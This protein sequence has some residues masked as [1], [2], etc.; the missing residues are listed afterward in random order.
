MVSSIT[1]RQASSGIALG[2]VLAISIGG[3]MLFFLAAGLLLAWR[4]KMRAKPYPMR[5]Y[6]LNP[7]ASSQPTS[8][9][10]LTKQRS[11][12][13][14]DLSTSRF[15]SRLSIS[16]PPVPLLPPL[17]T[18]NSIRT[19]AGGV[20]GGG[21]DGHAGRGRSRTWVDGD[22]LHG[23]QMGRSARES[24]FRSD[25]SVFNFRSPTLPNFDAAEQGEAQPPEAAPAAAAAA[26]A[27]AATDVV[28][29]DGEKRE[30]A[31]DR[32]IEVVKRQSRTM[33][34][35][36]QTVPILATTD[37]AQRGRARVP[38][39]SHIRLSFTDFDLRDIL[40][41]TEQRLRD[42]TSQSPTKKTPSTS[43]VRGGSPTKTPVSC[44]TTSSQGTVRVRR[45]DRSTPSPT[46]GA[47]ENMS[48]SQRAHASNE[49]L[50]SIGGMTIRLIAQSAQYLE[51]SSTHSS[52]ERSPERE[53]SDHKQQTGQTSPRRYSGRLSVESDASSSLSTLYSVEEPEEARSPRASDS[54]DPFVDNRI[55]I[56]RCLSLQAKT[57]LAGPRPMRKVGR[58]LSTS[59]LSKVVDQSAVPAP[60]RP[61][62]VNKQIGLKKDTAKSSKMSLV[63]QPPSRPQ[64]DDVGPKSPT[65]SRPASIVQTPSESSMVTET[66]HSDSEGGLT[67]KSD[68]RSQH[69][70]GSSPS[71]SRSTPVKG[72]GQLDIPSSPY[73]EHA[74]LSLL[75][76]GNSP[77]RALPTPPA[78]PTAADGRAD[79]AARTP[80]PDSKSGSPLRRMSV[81]S[82]SSSNYDEPAIDTPE[83][84]SPVL[85]S[86]RSTLKATKE[87]GQA[88]GSS[89]AQLRRMDSLVSSY[90][91]ASLSSTVM[92]DSEPSALPTRK[93]G[94][95]L[96]P[97][98]GSRAGGIG[99]K[100]FLN[101]G[102]PRH[103]GHSRSNLSWNHTTAIQEVED[104]DGGDKENQT[105]ELQMP[106][107]DVT[108]TSPAPALHERD[109]MDRTE[110]RGAPQRQTRVTFGPTPELIPRE[111]RQGSHSPRGSLESLGL[112]DKDGFLIGSPERNPKGRSWRM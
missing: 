54:N 67:P 112:Y 90:S 7:M 38:A 52:P 59:S 18:Y 62:S 106:R 4:L 64:S 35:G 33:I 14:P 21:S 45:S 37:D 48:T 85:S 12:F 72:D 103:K 57:H 36:S 24:W 92:E 55:H 101:M 84:G 73:D 110:G 109:Q 98:S 83:A 105:L 58:T 78:Q 79:S 15:S 82:S 86:Q 20:G 99:S 95:L 10:R 65:P 80:R 51:S 6:A 8:T 13:L 68:A 30:P 111:R 100:N 50:G 23:P 70:E 43:P 89:I 61:L 9:T 28:K 56:P 71:L 76:S 32:K 75:L 42:G 29:E 41:S 27:A 66:V 31:E 19:L 44:R 25:S 74:I 102:Q 17:P 60:L 1:P 81:A 94:N 5:V 104:K 39:Q 53:C 96:M 77:K 93:S 46:K 63:L 26:T 11:F 22:A 3:G 88:V 16:L 91:V 49:S 87:E 2:W 40:W 69:H 108:S 97:T 34:Q 47:A 107:I